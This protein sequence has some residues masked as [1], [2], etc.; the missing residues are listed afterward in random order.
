M[1]KKALAEAQKTQGA[2][3]NLKCFND[4]ILSYGLLPLPMVL[5]KVKESKGAGCAKQVAL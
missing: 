5:E 3:F 1:V 2:Q 4:E